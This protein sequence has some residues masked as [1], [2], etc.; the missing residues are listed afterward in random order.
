[1]PSIQEIATLTSKGQITLP[2]AVRQLLGLEAGGKVAFEIRDGEV[3]VTSA[4]SAHDDPVIG[5]FL[6]ILEADIRHG[7][8]TG[9]LPDELARAML[10]SAGRV[11]EHSD[12][13]DGD[14]EL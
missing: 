9:S 5:A 14:V 12:E 13:F 10:E 4:A 11:R 8:H 2:K 1:M 7:R 3:V 6:D